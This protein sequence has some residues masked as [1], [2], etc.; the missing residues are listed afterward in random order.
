MLKIYTVFF[1]VMT[2]WRNLNIVE[3]IWRRNLLFTNAQSA[4][5]LTLP[6]LEDVLNAENGILL[7][8]AFWIQMLQ[9]HL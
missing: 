5:T 7:K 8:S 6:G 4:A 9:N 1:V 3:K 2:F